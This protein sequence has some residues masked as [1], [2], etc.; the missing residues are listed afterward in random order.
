MSSCENMWNI[1]F[2]HKPY[3]ANYNEDLLQ[4]T[5]CSF[6]IGLSLKVMSIHLYVM[7]C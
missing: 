2:L 5:Q 6:I 4:F 3:D 1:I 7:L